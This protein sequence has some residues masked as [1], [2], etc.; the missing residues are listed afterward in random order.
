[1]TLDWWFERFGTVGIMLFAMGYDRYR[2][3]KEI[4]SR[5]QKIET[6][7]ERLIEQSKQG[8]AEAIR[9]EEQT[10]AQLERI[11]TAIQVGGLR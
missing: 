8:L 6:L 11:S 9:R 10:L 1:M 4:S 5:D 7:T 2:L 3:L